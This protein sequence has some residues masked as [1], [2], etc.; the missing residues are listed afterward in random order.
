MRSFKL[1]R[2]NILN[3]NLIKVLVYLAIPI[4]INAFITSVYNLIDA[5]F[6]SHIGEIEVTSIVFVGSIA[7]LLKGIPVGV[8]AG[9]TTLV[10]RHIGNGEYNIARKYAGNAIFFTT[11]VSIAF[12]ICGLFYSDNILYMFDATDNIVNASSMYFKINLFLSPVM[13]FNIVYLAIKN[14]EG[15]TRK[16]MNVN[17]ISILIKIV[18]NYVLIYLLDG[19]MV[20]L[21]ISTIFAVSVIGVY[22]I[23]DLFIKDG[24]M[25]LSVKDLFIENKILKLLLI[26]SVPIAIERM[27]VSYGFT[28][29]NEQVLYFG[30]DVLAAYGITNR[31]NS[32]AFG[33]VAGVGT[34]LSI[35][36]SQ[37]LSVG[38]IERCKE[39]IKK[40]FVV[41]IIFSII[42]FVLIFQYKYLF[43]DL[44][45][46]D[47]SAGAYLHTINAVNVITISVIPWSIFQIIIGI[48]RGTGYTKY[49]LYI[50][51][52]RIYL[53]RLPF[54]WLFV[55][56]LPQLQEY[57]VWYSVLL[58]N[59]ATALISIVIYYF[60]KD[61]F[62]MYTLENG[63]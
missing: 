5:V 47:E 33:A 59:I 24:L 27:S 41:N 49:G 46:F 23:Y 6:V 14:A 11:L 44:F 34:G 54:V 12:A 43:V 19:E 13:F 25:K 57:G 48:F 2:E 35:I 36:I 22:G 16:A 55:R 28:A 58:S 15:D 56:F 52:I 17:F 61:K 18:M 20:S 50:S 32:F 31:I 38:N 4:I 8:A 26:I 29:I 10:A 45:T 42:L 51:L 40:G 7:N 39:A 1:K 63:K 9:A 3:D 60:K 37:N 62:K 30:E 53:F 21:A